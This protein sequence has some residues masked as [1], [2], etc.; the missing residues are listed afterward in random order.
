MARGSLILIAASLALGATG[1][2]SAE[3]AAAPQQADKICRG[4][5]KQL[6][7]RMRSRRRCRTAEEWQEEDE[8]KA[9]LPITLQTTE[10]QN[11][12]RRGNAPR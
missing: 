12:D 10:G 5:E 8:A 11:H 7:S 4:G 9:R 1:P 6:G 2:L 3:P